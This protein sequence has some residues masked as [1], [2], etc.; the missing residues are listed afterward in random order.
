MEEFQK[1]LKS[2]LRSISETNFEDPNSKKQKS[3]QYN[4]NQY[5]HSYPQQSQFVQYS[6]PMQ[7][8]V[9]QTSELSV[10]P[11]DEDV[12]GKYIHF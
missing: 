4:D 9:Q 2:N 6:Y 3:E 12:D 1:K 11:K 8:Q 7:Y 5:Y 10:L